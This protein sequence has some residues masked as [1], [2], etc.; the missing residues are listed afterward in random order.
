MSPRVVR[1]GSLTGFAHGPASSFELSMVAR[2]GLAEI[3]EQFSVQDIPRDIM[4]EARKMGATMEDLLRMCG[5]TVAVATADVFMRREMDRLSVIKRAIVLS[6]DLAIK[7][8]IETVTR[9]QWC[10]F[11]QTQHMRHMEGLK[12]QTAR[13]FTQNHHFS[14]RDSVEASRS[15]KWYE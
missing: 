13:M 3:Y 11:A 5:N 6:G 1:L 9:E 8:G 14:T 4:D 10:D 2:G 15:G 7:G 12:W